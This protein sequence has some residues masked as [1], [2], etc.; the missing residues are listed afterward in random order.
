MEEKVNLINAARAAVCA[1]QSVLQSVADMAERESLTS[2]YTNACDVHEKL[3][4]VQLE[5]TN[6]E[7]IDE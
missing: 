5:L 2:L 7:S 6:M 4:D 3:H 1:A